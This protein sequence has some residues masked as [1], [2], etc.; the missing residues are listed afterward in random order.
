MDIGNFLKPTI[1]K[2]F[3]FLF[4]SLFYLYFAKESVCGVIFILAFCYSAYGFPFSYLI[5]GNIDAV[6][7]HFKTL[8][9]GENFIKYGSF[10]FNPA[11][12]F[13]NIIL[14]YLLSC[15]IANLIKAKN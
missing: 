9:L 11:A 3:I 14:I 2:I 6:A 8:F 5:T 10:L 4:I 12:F 1:L 7:G 13:L 15:F